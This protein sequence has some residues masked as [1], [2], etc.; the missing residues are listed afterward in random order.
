MKRKSRSRTKPELNSPSKAKPLDILP[1]LTEAEE[2]ESRPSTSSVASTSSSG[3]NA[4]L[5][6]NYCASRSFGGTHNS[7]IQDSVDRK[8]GSR[9]VVLTGAEGL[10]FEDFFPLSTEPPRPAPSPPTTKPISVE[11]RRP[12]SQQSFVVESP[13]DSID[14]RFSGLNIPFNFPSSPHTRRSNS[15]TSSIASSRTTSSTASS[16]STASRIAI[17]TPP[18]SDDESHPKS[19]THPNLTRVSTHKSHRAS[20]HYIKS[21]PDLV[22]STRISEPMPQLS[23]DD[24]DNSEDVSWFA[25]ELSDIV[26]IVPDTADSMPSTPK[27]A[28]HS[29]ARPDSV[30]P[31]SRSSGRKRQSKPLPAV[32]RLSIQISSPRGPSVQL[33]P[34]FPERKR[35]PIPSR[36]PPPP[37]IY[38]DS[39]PSPTMEEKTD[40]LLALLANAALDSGFTGTGLGGLNE[41]PPSLPVTPS[42]EFAVY[43][44]LPSRP[45][46]RMS[47]PADINDFLD[48]ERSP[49]NQDLLSDERDDGEGLEFELDDDYLP[50]PEWPRTPKGVSVYPQASLSIDAIPLEPET[51]KV[52]SGFDCS[53]NSMEYESPLSPAMPDSPLVGMYA[54]NALQRPLR[55][56]WSS[57]TLSS[58][59]DSRQ[60]PSS[61]STWKLR[62]HIG[63]SSHSKE[64]DKLKAS[65]SRPSLK[66][67]KAT[68]LSPV[69]QSSV[70]VDRR[71]SS[72]SG[73][74]DGGTESADSTANSGTKRKPI[75]LEIFL[76][77]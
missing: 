58:L 47:V 26:T 30:F 45:P 65:I 49:D 40:E 43:T 71:N 48:D 38:I 2:E 1:G 74:S 73:H 12:F 52:N 28:E 7:L 29:R 53:M 64:A 27:L 23:R 34:T 67:T 46:P 56:Q 50:S 36:A 17:L 24:G 31:A 25:Q 54:F 18:T 42:S 9:R 44:P 32:P 21:V 72:S 35:Y 4:F 22:R 51:P 41:F 15:P 69:M 20:V 66:P 68:P 60:T 3:S 33:D 10:T 19:Q 70:P 13:L 6:P 39:P 61:P 11:P 16:S 57:S 55:S 5:S 76:R 59:V 77:N 63:S 62:F 37:P 8:R 75:P 14:F